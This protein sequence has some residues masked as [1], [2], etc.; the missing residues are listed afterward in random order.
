MHWNK[1]HSGL[2]NSQLPRGTRA[3]PLGNDQRSLELHESIQ[4]CAPTHPT[5]GGEKT[6]TPRTQG[7]F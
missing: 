4:A 7:A 3:S 1:F 5:Q 2:D 6:M